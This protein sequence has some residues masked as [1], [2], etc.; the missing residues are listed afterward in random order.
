MLSE[1]VEHQSQMNGMI[2]LILG[3]DQNIIEIDQDEFIG[4]GVEDEIHQARE[5]WRSIDKAERYD[6]IFIRT[7]ACSECCLGNIFFTNANLMI[8]HTKIKLGEHFSTFE[9]LKKLI[10]VGKWVLVLDCLLVQWTVIDA[11]S[12]CAILLLDKKNTT[13]PWRRTRSDQTQ[14][15]LF[16]ELFLQFLQLFWPKIVWTLANGFRAR[17]KI[18]N[19]FNWPVGRHTRKLFWKDILVLTNDWNLRDNIQFA[20]L[21]ERK[22]PNG[23]ITSG[24]NDHIVRR[25]SQLNFPGSTIKLSLVLRKPVHPENKINIRV[26]KNNWFSQKSIVTHLDRDIG[27]NQARRQKFSR[28]NNLH[29]FGQDLCVNIM[30]RCKRI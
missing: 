3:E 18:N 25:V 15:L 22:Q 28:R 14:T 17:L 24:I 16:I 27:S 30:L 10:D 8:T 2:L 7:I 1:L 6:S 19:E 21:I 23:I 9:L 11:K 4:V 26:T 20:I 13:T 12:V 29:N 5:C